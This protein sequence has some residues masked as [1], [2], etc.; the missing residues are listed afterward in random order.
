MP[1]NATDIFG[2]GNALLIPGLPLAILVQGTAPA[3]GL[4]VTVVHGVILGAILIPGLPCSYGSW[5]HNGHCTSG[6]HWCW[7]CS[8]NN[9]CAG[10]ICHGQEFFWKNIL[11]LTFLLVHQ[12]PAPTRY[13]EMTLCPT[14]TGYQV[15]LL[16][17]RLHSDAHHTVPR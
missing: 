13:T 4:L 17:K 2:Q 14:H 7:L 6:S 3:A 1:A 12:L 16:N 15:L 10:H 8:C 11:I 9:P 5:G